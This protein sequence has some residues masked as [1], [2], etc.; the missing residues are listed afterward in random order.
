MYELSDAISIRSNP[1][2]FV[3]AAAIFIADQ[4]PSVRVSL[5][6]LVRLGGWHPKPISSAEE[7][8]GCPRSTVPSCLILDVMFPG[9]DELQ[10]QLADR[11]ELP[12]IFITA[13]GCVPLAVQAAMRADCVRFLTKPFDERAML[14]A[15]ERALEWSKNSLAQEAESR[16]LAGRHSTLT[17]REREVFG[18][19]IAGL[20]NKQIG[21]ELGISE[22]TVKAHRGKVMRKMTA[23]SLAELVRMAVRL[24]V[25]PTAKRSLRHANDHRSA[26]VGGSTYVTFGSSQFSPAPRPFVSE[27]YGVCPTGS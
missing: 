1:A 23:D 19:V 20:L 14:G 15:I 21:S 25:V 13:F 5:E 16:T 7:F 24:R 12:I 10:R 2:N 17:A 27:S 22:I 4:D 26:S 18:L 8:F 9:F 6:R 3:G 11:P